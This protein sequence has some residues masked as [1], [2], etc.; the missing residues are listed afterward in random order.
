[1]TKV[2]LLA[3]VVIINQ[4]LRSKNKVS[5]T[6]IKLENVVDFWNFIN[7]FTEYGSDLIELAHLSGERQNVIQ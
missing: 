2:L 3:D 4:L 5:Q 7:F 1:M 6:L